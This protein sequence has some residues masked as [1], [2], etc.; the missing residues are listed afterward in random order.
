MKNTTF[1]EINNIEV[2]FNG[3]YTRLYALFGS[4]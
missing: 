4:A 3:R 2:T 1:K